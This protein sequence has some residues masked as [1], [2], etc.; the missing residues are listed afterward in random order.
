MTT[1]PTSEAQARTPH[2]GEAFAQ[3]RQESARKSL[4]VSDQP[5]SSEILVY[6]IDELAKLLH[7]STRTIGN[8]LRL[9]RLVGRK[10]GRR[11]VIPRSSVE[12]F[13]KRDHPGREALP[14]P[15]GEE[16]KRPRRGSAKSTQR[17]SL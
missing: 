13:L 11:T 9:R 17:G 7:V 10:I 3:G 16:G 5:S 14:H 4:R 6:E 1:E 15:A 2:K 8:M 12:S